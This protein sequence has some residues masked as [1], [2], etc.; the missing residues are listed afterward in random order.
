MACCR[1]ATNKAVNWPSGDD[2]PSSSDPLVDFDVP[3]GVNQAANCT[4]GP[5]RR[6]GSRFVYRIGSPIAR[7]PTSPSRC[8]PT[9]IIVPAGGTQV[10][11]VQ[12]TPHQ[13][14]RPDRA[15]ARRP[16]ERAALAGNVIPPG[17]TIGLL[18]LSAQDGSP[19][20][21]AD[22]CRRPGPRIASPVVPRRDV[23]RRSRLALSA[24]I[25][26]QVGLAIAAA[27]PIGLAWTP[28]RTTSSFSAASCRRSV[29]LPRREG[30]TGSI[31]V[32]LLTTQP[33]PKKNDQGE[34]PGQ[35]GR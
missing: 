13:L 32:R 24:A 2:R 7:G 29:Q 30:T 9:A 26:E 6:G 33:M 23:R 25:R 22:A 8:P 10:V 17:A 11:P 16:A 18:T 12:V 28:A 20:A 35:G 19:Q 15:V 31:R 27:S 34:Q 4:Q 1:S 3:A 21:R 14:Q 5:E